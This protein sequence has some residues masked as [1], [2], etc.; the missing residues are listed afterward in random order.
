MSHFAQQELQLDTA[1]VQR[2]MS[3]KTSE[4]NYIHF[5]NWEKL[6]QS[7]ESGHV[8]NDPVMTV[9]CSDCPRTL[10][11]LLD[12]NEKPHHCL[13]CLIGGFCRI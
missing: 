12:W 4:N 6:V 5:Q 7:L 3:V 9:F 10:E 13:F 11:K 2:V 8:N 1:S